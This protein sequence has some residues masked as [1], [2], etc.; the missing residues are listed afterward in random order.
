MTFDRLQQ[1]KDKSV[2]QLEGVKGW[3]KVQEITKGARLPE[4]SRPADSRK[5]EMEG[6]K[7]NPIQIQF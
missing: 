7:E 2:V 4:D 6:N 5:R 1:G 3:L